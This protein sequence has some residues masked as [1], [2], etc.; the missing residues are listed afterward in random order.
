MRIVKYWNRSWE[1]VLFPSLA[2]FKTC[3]D[4][5]LSALVYPWAGSTLS[6]RDGTGPSWMHLCVYLSILFCLF[7]WVPWKFKSWSFQPYL[8]SSCLGYLVYSACLG[9]SGSPV[10]RLGMHCW[11][12]QNKSGG[13]GDQQAFS[14]VL[15]SGLRRESM[16]ALTRIYTSIIIQC[17]RNCFVSTTSL[18]FVSGCKLF[19]PTEQSLSLILKLF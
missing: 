2:V 16:K 14:C 9:V 1:F 15:L 13:H 11:A 10:L 17:Y 8:Q 4:K 12:L 7:R 6:M 5:A 19:L 3:L 18:C